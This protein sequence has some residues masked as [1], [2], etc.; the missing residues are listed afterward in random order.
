MSL[1][2]LRFA[3]FGFTITKFDDDLNPQG[4]YNVGNDPNTG[5]LYCDCPAGQRHTCRHR[6]MLPIFLDTNRVNTN[7]FYDYDAKGWRQYVGPFDAEGATY[8]AEPLVC[9][10]EM[11]ATEVEARITAAK[12]QPLPPGEYTCTIKHIDEDG[13]GTLK[14]ED[15]TEFKSR[16][17]P[18][19]SFRRRV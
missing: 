5:Q 4:S 19:G 3:D 16:L 10:P 12:V 17:L 15:G 1:Y 9:G 14:L 2:N 7:W 18:G 6:E 8:T 11:T 13:I